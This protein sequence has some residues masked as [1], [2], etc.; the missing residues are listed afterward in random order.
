LNSYNGPRPKPAVGRAED[1]LAPLN[2]SDGELELLEK[3][4]NSLNSPVQ[5][6][7]P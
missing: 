4:L 2:L 7:T 1:T 3:F 6:L 5:G